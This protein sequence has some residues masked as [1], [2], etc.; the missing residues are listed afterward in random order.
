MIL[1]KDM[2]DSYTENYETLFRETKE[3]LNYWRVQRRL[4]IVKMSS[5]PKLIYKYNA[6]LVNIS[7]SF[8]C[9]SLM[10]SF[11]VSSF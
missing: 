6:V 9:F 8:W 10:R 4:N 3:F 1:I 5:N 11:I 7:A 2:K